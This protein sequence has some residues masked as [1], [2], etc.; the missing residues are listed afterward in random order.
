MKIYLFLSFVVQEKHEI[1]SLDLFDLKENYE[2]IPIQIT[3][4][5]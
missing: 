4:H 1:D 5:H 2:S 3:M